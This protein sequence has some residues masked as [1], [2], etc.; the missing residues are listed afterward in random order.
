MLSP[1]IRRAG[2]KPF[3]VDIKDPSLALYIPAW[4]QDSET[5][6]STIISKD[7][8]RHSCTV[9][10]ATWGL[11]GRT[12]DGTDDIITVATSAAFGNLWNGGGGAG[13]WIYPDSDGEADAGNILR[14]NANSKGWLTF[15]SIE[16]GGVAQF[17]F[18]CLFSVAEGQ[19]S[20]T[21]KVLNIG[22]WNFIWV[23][24]DSSSDSNNPTF[25]ING[26]TYTVGDGITEDQAP[27]GTV[28]DD[29]GNDLTIGNNAATSR[30]FDGV[31]ADTI[32]YGVTKTSGFVE[33]FRR[34]TK[35]RYQ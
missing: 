18:Y 19:W 24:F 30:T 33:D 26:T 8:N 1:A 9:T 27:D 23:S 5:T 12:F 21:S 16:A 2:R 7:I 10:G 3:P 28:I 4:Y 11:Q 22:A 14:T 13:V 25:Y 34:N 20:T 29:T 31:I 17:N 6:G 35:W 32:L 15:I